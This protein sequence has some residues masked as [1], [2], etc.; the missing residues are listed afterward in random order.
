MT[1]IRQKMRPAMPMVSVDQ[2]VDM[3]YGVQC[4]AVLPI[5]AVTSTLAESLT[6][7]FPVRFAMRSWRTVSLKS[8][9]GFPIQGGLL[10]MSVTR[11][12]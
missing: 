10:F 5:G 7:R 11:T 3:P 12:T 1:S 9:A 2:L 6:T 8:T 4:A